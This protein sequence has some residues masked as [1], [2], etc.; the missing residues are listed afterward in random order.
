M[1]NDTFDYVENSRA[2]IL[3]IAILVVYSDGYW[4]DLERDELEGAYRNICV[5]LDEDLDDDQLLR[6]LDEISTDVAEQIED[7]AGDDESDEYWQG[8][9]DAIS[10]EDIQQV[11]VGAAMA[12]AGGDSEIDADEMDGIARLCV[13]WDVSVKDALDIWND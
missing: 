8:C 6:E 2:A 9:L 7:L 13:A 1:N 5:L 3:R 12:L 4:H 11:A 10:A